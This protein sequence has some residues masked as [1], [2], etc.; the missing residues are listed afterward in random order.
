MFHGN[1]CDVNFR[2]HD[3]PT[4]KSIFNE[5]SWSNYCNETTLD[6]YDNNDYFND[7][8]YNDNADDD[9]EDEERET[10]HLYKNITFITSAVQDCVRSH[11]ENAAYKIRV[12][13]FQK[14]T[15][16]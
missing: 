13:I 10:R 9:Y 6:Y 1:Y 11:H 2:I 5:T 8:T 16:Y 12:I 4:I 15:K 7:S 14:R 3:L